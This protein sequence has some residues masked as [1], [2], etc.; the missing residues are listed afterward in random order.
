M[1]AFTATDLTTNLE[2]S[3][4][5][6]SLGLE[7]GIGN[8]WQWEGFTLGVTWLGYFNPL[9]ASSSKDIPAETVGSTAA[10]D[11]DD[12]LDSLGETPNMQLFRISAGWAF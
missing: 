7:F 5:A 1:I 6:N 8:R 9:S 4:E 10:N 3:T 12:A 2:V 11:L